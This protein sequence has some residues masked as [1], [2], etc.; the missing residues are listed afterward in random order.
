VAGQTIRVGT[1][2]V[3][4]SITVT[5]SATGTNHSTGSSSQSK[6]SAHTARP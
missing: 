5:A 4:R 1:I 6:P 3:R 2:R